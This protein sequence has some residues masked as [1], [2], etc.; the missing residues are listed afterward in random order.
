MNKWS[1]AWAVW[2]LIGIAIEMAAL[3]N[4]TKDDTLSENIWAVY[5]NPT[6]G[7]FIAWMFT[8][9]LLWMCLHFVYRGKL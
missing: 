9:F 5:A 8:A 3:L 2:V 6:F 4:K 7:K 1:I